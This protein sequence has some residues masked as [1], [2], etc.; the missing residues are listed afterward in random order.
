MGEAKGICWG[1]FSRMKARF[2]KDNVSIE[3]AAEQPAET[4]DVP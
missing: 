2:L 3:L 1:S 4:G